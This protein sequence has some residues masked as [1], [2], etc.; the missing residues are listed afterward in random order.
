MYQA[1]QTLTQRLHPGDQDSHF[2]MIEGSIHQE[3][4]TVINLYAVNIR[5]SKSIKQ[6]PTY[7]KRETDT[8]T[9]INKGQVTQ[10]EN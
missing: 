1:R 6:T 4:T 2:A 9:H 5:A 3:A 10:T 8:N 7:L